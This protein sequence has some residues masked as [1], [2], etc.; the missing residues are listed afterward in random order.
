MRNKIMTKSGKCSPAH[1]HK[2]GSCIPLGVLV[3]IAEA[4]NHDKQQEEIKISQNMEVLNPGKYKEYL[5]KEL[6]MRLGEKQT[7]WK[8][9]RLCKGI[10]GQG[11]V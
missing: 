7:C 2:H 9:Q 5:V 1:E 8:D 4:Y 6:T 3:N 11:Q 10:Y